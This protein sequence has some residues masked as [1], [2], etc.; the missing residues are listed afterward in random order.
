[1]SLEIVRSERGFIL[2]TGVG[3]LMVER[4]WNCNTIRC[5]SMLE[6]KASVVRPGAL[7]PSNSHPRLRLVSDDTSHH[8]VA[9]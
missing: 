2:H 7:R 8:S 1:M 4:S 9:T 6:P 3:V 5:R